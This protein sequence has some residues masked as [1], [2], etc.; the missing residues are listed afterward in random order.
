[1]TGP[2]RATMA[3]AEGG[4]VTV[5]PPNDCPG[6]TVSR[7]VP[8]ASICA[9]SWARL[10]PETPSTATMVAM[11]SATPTAESAA[12]AGLLTRPRTASDQVSAGRRR[13]TGR[14]R[15][16]RAPGPHARPAVVLDQPVA[17]PDHPPRGLGYLRVVGNHEDRRPAAV[18]LGQQGEDA[19]AGR[20]VQAAGRLV[21]Q[22]DGGPPGQRPGDGDALALAA[23][24]F[25]G[26]V[27]GP[28]GQADLGQRV[29]RGP[30]PPRR[31]DTAVQQPGG[32]VVQ[33]GQRG[34]QEELLEHEPDPGGPTP[35]R[36][37][38]GSP[39]TTSPATR[40]LPAVG[41]SRVPAMAS[42]VDLPDP[43]G[44]TIAVNSPVPIV[45]V[46]DLSAATGG[47]PGCSLDTPMSSR[48]LAVPFTGP[49]PPWSRP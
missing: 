19:R 44:P 38:S 22:D 40:T 13:L 46:T 36:A 26:T 14:A 27:A 28:A 15:P 24:Q 12:R 18:Q 23:G 4:S 39:S 47:E 16:V 33:R 8:S 9:T 32:H 41:R 3:G 1:M 31:G 48:A 5:W 30:A 43:D 37:L 20:R 42:M 49:P 7:L 21:G 11:P 2:I 29:R 10:E 45:T 35:D 6:A 17:Q 25:G 34:H